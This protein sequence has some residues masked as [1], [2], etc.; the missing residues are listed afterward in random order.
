MGRDVYIV[1]GTRTPIGDFGGSLVNVSATE[2]A[3]LVIK[4]AI[5]R[6]NLQKEDIDF[7][8]MGNNMDPLASNIARIALVKAGLPLKVPGISTACTCGSGMQAIING[9]QTIREGEADILVVAELTMA[10]SELAEGRLAVVPFNPPWLH[11]D[12][13][14]ISRLNRTLSPATIRF[15]E[16]VRAIET[17][18][19]QREMAL[20]NRFL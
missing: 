15:K 1:N 3:I 9:F 6:S 13:G 16:I 19:D 2:L 7:V 5:A 17:E 18:L 8:Y 12:Y 14:F 10:E 11:L 4:S 20:R